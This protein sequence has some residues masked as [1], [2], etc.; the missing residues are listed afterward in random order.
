MAP[1]LATYRSAVIV[2][3][4]KEIYAAITKV[5]RQHKIRRAKPFN[6][7]LLTPSMTPDEVAQRQWRRHL[8]KCRRIVER[9]QWQLEFDYYDAH[10]RW[11]RWPR[12]SEEFGP[13]LHWTQRE[14]IRDRDRERERKASVADF[15][16]WL[17][18]QPAH[19]QEIHRRVMERMRGNSG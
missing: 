9:A 10:Y 11:C 13:F 17:A 6:H 14:R 8:N 2:E 7:L 3:N 5:M 16:V 18:E 19:V 12:W 15:K 1:R 4:R